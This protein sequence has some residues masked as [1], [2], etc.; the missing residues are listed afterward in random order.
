M[1]AHSDQSGHQNSQALKPFQKI[2]RT[3]FMD[4]SKNPRRSLSPPRSGRQGG[5]LAEILQSPAIQQALAARRR[6]LQ[7]EQ[8]PANPSAGNASGGAPGQ[9][10]TPQ[11]AAATP[12]DGG[13]EID[14]DD[15]GDSGDVPQRAIRGLLGGLPHYPS[16]ASSSSGKD[17]VPEHSG[18]AAPSAPSSFL[19]SAMKPPLPPST[20]PTPTPVPP[21]D[22]T[23]SQSSLE[24]GS[25]ISNSAT[26][27]PPL[28]KSLRSAKNFNDP[29]TRANPK[30][31][32][33]AKNRYGLWS[34]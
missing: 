19:L 12:M 29:C 27:A 26:S 16:L 3:V 24:L 5:G 15:I 13:V 34:Y 11:V 8:T 21:D 2:V 20:A 25:N 17:V 23:S 6:A 1:V 33:G 22:G 28:R 18:T 7:R 32:A 31:Y 9:S 4:G 14:G 10:A 30:T